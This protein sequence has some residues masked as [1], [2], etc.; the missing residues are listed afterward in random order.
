MPQ[1]LRPST[2]VPRGLISDIAVSDADGMLITV[3]PVAKTNACPG[4][5]RHSARIHSHYR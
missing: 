3:R 5:G 4:C 2:L 1:T